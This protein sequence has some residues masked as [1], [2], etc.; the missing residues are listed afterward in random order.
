MKVLINTLLL[1][2][3]GVLLAQTA[4][5][6]LQ[7]TK[8]SGI[9]SSTTCIDNRSATN[10]QNTTHSFF[11]SG[12]GSW[13]V[14]LQHSQTSCSGPWTS[15]GSTGLVTNAASIPIGYGFD[16]A[17]F[18][19]FVSFAIT[20]SVTITYTG[21]HGLFFPSSSGGSV[22]FPIMV[23][24]GGTGLTSITLN[25]IPYGQG[26]ST[27]GVTAAG[28]AD[29]V[30][31]VPSGGN[32]PAFGAV[33]LSAAA[34]TT[35]Q[36][37]I[38]SG[39]TGAGTASAAFNNLSPMTTLGDII[40]GGTSGAGTRLAGDTSN[41][42]KFLR[43]ESSGSVATAPVWDVLQTGDLPQL[44][45]VGSAGTYTKVTTDAQGRVSSGTQANF[46]DLAGSIALA[47]TPLTTNGDIMFV[48][49]G[50][51]SRL[52]IAGSGCIGVSGGTLAYVACSGGSG[53]TVINDVALTSP[54]LVVANGGSHVTLGSLIGDVTTSG[55]TATLAASGV[56]GS[57]CGDST[58]SCGL[59]YDTKGRLTAVTNN[60]INP[61]T[62]N[63]LALTN[64]PVFDVRS[65][66]FGSQSPGGSL[67]GGILA[68]V[69]LTPCPVGVTGSDTNHWLYVSGGTGTAEAVL[70]S[71][72]SCTSGLG[73]GSVQFTPV[74]NH[75]G[76]WSIGPATGGWQEAVNSA[77]QTGTILGYPYGTATFHAAVTIPS[78]ANMAFTCLNSTQTC[79][80][81]A[82]DYLSGDLFYVNGNCSSPAVLAWY[83]LSI[84]D[85]LGTSG[86]AIHEVCAQGNIS[87]IS[88]NHSGSTGGATGLLFDS[89]SSVFSNNFL[90]FSS[91]TT[92]TGL[93]IVGNVA[94][95]TIIYFTGGS[96]FLPV[97][98]GTTYAVDMTAGD[99]VVFDHV[100]F[101]GASVELNIHPG[102]CPNCTGA[103]KVL[104]GGF[105][106]YY[107]N[108]IRL[109]P[110]ST[111]MDGS[112]IIGAQIDGASSGTNTYGIDWGCTTTG[113]FTNAVFTGNTIQQNG[114][115]G[116]C[117][118]TSTNPTY[119][120]T[121]LSGNVIRA[122][123][124][125]SHSGDGGVLLATTT[126]VS[127]SGGNI[128]T[129]NTGCGICTSGSNAHV[130][131]TGNNIDSNT[132][133][134]S[135]ATAMPTDFTWSGNNGQAGSIALPNGQ[136]DNVNAGV[137]TLLR[138]TGPSSSYSIS[139]FSGG[140][141]G[142]ML[143]LISSTVQQLTILNLTGSSA[144]NQIQT[145]TG[146]NVVLSSGNGNMVQFMY[147]SAVGAWLLLNHNP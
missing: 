91:S 44:P 16:G 83:Q 24:S 110:S 95:P 119:S 35:G 42:R 117:I 41:T 14:Q 62:A 51:L 126:G 36:L 33:N 69:T 71:G 1:L 145:V 8:I 136:S 133:P 81:R 137:A 96:F 86:G 17:T 105:D 94:K 59:A 144:G 135:N 47:Q 4:P 3:P 23:N 73:T 43:E 115:S 25:G 103:L 79:V 78:N 53:G 112:Q 128:I 101:S 130:S 13:S 27:I 142:R 98:T 52:P 21:E 147:S 7:V 100:N 64:S 9:T 56:S 38:P 109:T 132:T 6:P 127:I 111:T 90:Y 76:A 131:V 22:S 82:S 93:S 84:D 118:G 40:Y 72:G 106:N 26:G 39:G 104:G 120:S 11:V 48:S 134:L 58:H 97:G 10:R 124:T 54:G 63:W 50:V 108:A 141:D 99:N 32:P 125:R 34:A 89:V 31:V 139:G 18:F 2:V 12:S 65:Y 121:S 28:S 67:T 74:N 29:Q 138:V 55:L 46:T 88:V 68:T 102:S 77:I 45:S 15:Y 49:G 5:S 37:I 70:I 113:A 61:G 57:S 129:G 30:F 114:Y 143:T 20:G 92:A 60:S 85:G 107:L 87:N 123:N 66:N 75:T 116:I 122:N 146:S 19:N 80:V 140:W